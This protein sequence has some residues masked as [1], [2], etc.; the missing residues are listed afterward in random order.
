MFAEQNG[1]FVSSEGLIQR[2]RPCFDPLGDARP[3]WSWLNDLAL[4]RGAEPGPPDD[5]GR[6][7]R[8]ADELPF[9]SGLRLETLDPLGTPGHGVEMPKAPTPPGLRQPEKEEALR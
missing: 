5:S 4:R 8:M 2:I 1:T 7:A 9:F 6:F 3:E